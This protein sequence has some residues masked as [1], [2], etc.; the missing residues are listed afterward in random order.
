M[1]PLSLVADSG[2]PDARRIP[3]A[4]RD[5]TPSA[6]SPRASLRV[7]LPSGCPSRRRQRPKTCAQAEGIASRHGRRVKW[8][9]A[10][11]GSWSSCSCAP[12]S[13]RSDS[14]CRRRTW[15]AREVRVAVR[16]ARAA[17]RSARDHRLPGDRASGSPLRGSVHEHR[18]ARARPRRHDALDVLPPRGVRVACPDVRARRARPPGADDFDDERP[19]VDRARARHLRVDGRGRY[20]PNPARGRR[21]GNPAIPRHDPQEVPRCARGLL[22]RAVRRG[23]AHVGSRPRPAGACRRE[24]RTGNRDRRRARGRHARTD[25]EGRGERRPHGASQRIS[26]GYRR[27]VRD[28]LPLRRRSDG[29]EAHTA[30]RGRSSNGRRNSRVHDRARNLTGRDRRGSDVATR[31]PPIPPRCVGSHERLAANSSLQATTRD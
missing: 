1:R 15:W 29:W 17:G 28:P 27:S 10:V 16:A 18:C 7:R 5:D 6:G 19:D 31:T 20:P 25:L 23:A 8:C 22:R 9:G 2:D 3:L 24:R 13:G 4:V 14:R 26:R 30:R 11:A 12:L 21:R